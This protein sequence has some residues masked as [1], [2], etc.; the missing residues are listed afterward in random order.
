MKK[1]IFFIIT[2]FISSSILYAQESGADKRVVPRE[3]NVFTNPSDNEFIGKLGTGYASDPGKFGLDL[4]LNYIYNLD[5]VFVFG[6][7]GDFFWIKWKNELGDVNA[8]GA[9][10]GSEVATTD[11]YTFPVFANAQIRLPFLKSRIYV[12]PSLTVGLGYCFMILDYSSDTEDG[13]DLYTGFAWQVF[14][15]AAYKIFENSAVDFVLDL[16]YRG[17]SPEKDQVEID[18]SGIIARIGVRMYI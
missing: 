4:S 2:F 14:G 12:E 5:P 9:A 1:I 3:K 8:G 16:G 7:E 6:F 18:M 13:T 11:L 17:L 10:G 15:S